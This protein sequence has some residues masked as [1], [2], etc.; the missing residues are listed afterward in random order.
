MPPA[1]TD[2]I[3][4]Y[5][6]NLSPALGMKFLCYPM[7]MA[8]EFT[9]SFHKESLEVFRYYKRLA[10]RSMAQL[11]DPDFFR[12][13]DNDA[14]SIAVILKHLTGNMRSRFTNFLTEDGE[15]P[16][17]NRDAEFEA[18]LLT[19]EALLQDWEAAWNLVFN[20]L[21]A[22]TEDHLTRA[23]TVRGDPH[24]VMQAI[25]RQVA[26]YSHHIGQIVLLAKHYK[27]ADWKT[28]SIPKGQSEEFTRRVKAGEIPQR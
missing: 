14:N 19:R 15:K 13:I 28:P 5:G 18:P 20:E 25:L 4:E 2:A 1:P 21:E 12:V 10:D 3:S 16:W 24:S 7:E 22:L 26:H 23:V 17:R 11:D 9:T 6:P 8:L 27:G